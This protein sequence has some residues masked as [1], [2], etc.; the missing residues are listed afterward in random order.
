[1]VQVAVLG[2]FAAFGRRSLAAHRKKVFEAIQVLAA[3]FQDVEARN[4]VAL[5]GFVEAGVGSV[6]M[7]GVEN[8]HMNHSGNSEGHS[9]TEREARLETVVDHPETGSVAGLDKVPVHLGTGKD[10][11]GR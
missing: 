2:A 4:F 1:M 3:D 10:H 9:G 6:G 11:L 7:E 5:Y 8:P